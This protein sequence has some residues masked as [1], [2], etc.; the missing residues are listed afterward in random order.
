VKADDAPA[1]QHFPITPS[2]HRELLVSAI[3]LS[4]AHAPS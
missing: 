3:T 1:T 4:D 2:F